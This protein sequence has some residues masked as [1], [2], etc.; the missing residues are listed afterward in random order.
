MT[1]SKL[2]D[3]SDEYESINPKFCHEITVKI[4]RAKYAGK[5]RLIRKKVDTNAC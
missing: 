2:E 3:E 1:Q 4:L 5:T